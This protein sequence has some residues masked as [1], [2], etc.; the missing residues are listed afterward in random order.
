MKFASVSFYYQVSD[1]GSVGWAFSL[2]WD[3]KII[4][5]MANLI[6]LMLL[7]SLLISTFN[8]W[9]KDK[10]TESCDWWNVQI[11]RV[12]IL[13]IRSQQQA[14]VESRPLLQELSIKFKCVKIFYFLGI[15][16]KC[17]SFFQMKLVSF[18]S[19]H[20]PTPSKWKC[21]KQNTDVL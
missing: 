5:T 4:N 14:L 13:H 2:N 17:D 18:G 15:V 16:A 9:L 10:D 3:Q 7:S 20:S 1:T 8:K 19:D 21:E 6:S 12:F 11:P